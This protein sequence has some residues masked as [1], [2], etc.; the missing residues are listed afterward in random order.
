MT[1]CV[2]R[3]LTL[4]MAAMNA[5]KAALE[6]IKEG[7]SDT[8]TD[9]A[10]FDELKGVIGFPQYYDEEKRY[11]PYNYAADGDSIATLD[12][13]DGKSLGGAL[14]PTTTSPSAGK[15]AA[16]NAVDGAGQHC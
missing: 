6:D 8:K 16:V 4:L 15:G 9:K 5:M 7:N 10:S 1:S 2:P 12:A 14:L 11:A 3:T 13:T